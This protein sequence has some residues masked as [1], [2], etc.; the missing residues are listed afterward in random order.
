MVYVYIMC[1]FHAVIDSIRPEKLDRSVKLHGLEYIDVPAMGRKDYRLNFYAHK[2]GSFTA[3]VRDPCSQ[4]LVVRH[5][6]HSH[7]PKISPCVYYVCIY[8]LHFDVANLW[9]LSYKY[10]QYICTYIH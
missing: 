5:V 4:H 8:I 9:F 2:E 6:P 10:I 1:R 7:E 3:K